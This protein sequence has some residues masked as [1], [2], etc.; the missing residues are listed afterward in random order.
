MSE[1]E[2][3][4]HAAHAAEYFWWMG[5]SN[6]TSH[7]LTMED[8]RACL[9]DDEDARFAFSLF[10]LDGDGYVVE[11]EVQGRFQKMYRCVPRPARVGRLCCV[12]ALPCSTP[13]LCVGPCSDA[14]GALLW[15]RRCK[16]GPVCAPSTRGSNG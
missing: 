14:P 7:K 6:I 13:P 1:I 3:D 15:G 5:R 9:S 10:D 16:P 12:P 2:L 8:M 4:T 11:E